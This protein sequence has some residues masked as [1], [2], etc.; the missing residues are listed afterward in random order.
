[1]SVALFRIAQEAL[2]NVS[3]HSGAGEAWV[4][5]DLTDA[6]VRLTVGDDG[7]RVRRGDA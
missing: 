7:Q 5:L 4:M 2:Q 1:M 6:G 3:R